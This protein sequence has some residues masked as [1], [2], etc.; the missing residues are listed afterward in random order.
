[1]KVELKILWIF[2][3]C[4]AIKSG[5]T[6]WIDIDRKQS[7]FS[8][9]KPRRQENSKGRRFYRRPLKKPLSTVI[10]SVLQQL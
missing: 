10:N 3:L 6:K 8:S 7:I 5:H 1:M 9:D 2:P 4:F